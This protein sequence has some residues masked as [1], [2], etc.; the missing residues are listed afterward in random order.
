MRRINCFYH[1]KPLTGQS[2]RPVDD[3]VRFSQEPYTSF[4]PSTLSSLRIDK[5]DQKPRLA[6]RFIGLFGP[7]GP[8]PLHLTEYARDRE[9]HKHDASFSRFADMFHHRVVSLYYAAWAQAQPTVQFDRP[10]KNR[11]GDYLGSLI[12]LGFPSLRDADAMHHLSK[13][14]FAGHLGSLPRHVNGLVS[15]I[16]GYFEIEVKVVEFIGHWIRIPKA[17]QVMLGMGA[18]LGKD[19]VIGERV[20]QRQDKFRLCLGPLSLDQY[21]A[22]LPDG[23]SFSALVAAV[24]NYV[25]IEYFWEVNLIL[26]KEEKPVSCLGKCGRL[27]WTNWL[28]SAPQLNHVDDLNLQVENYIN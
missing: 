7:N 2:Y 26:R 19:T 1:D 16:S 17:D 15:L 12:G 24:R 25:G 11:F 27:G 23:K 22:F 18:R 5:S 13:L 20:W 4:A 9:R 14:S 10:D 3:P 6:Q 21:E 28:E 8:L